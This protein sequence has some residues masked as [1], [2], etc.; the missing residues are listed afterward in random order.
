MGEKDPILRLRQRIIELKMATETELTRVDEEAR[1]E[2]E[3][4]KNSA[5]KVHIL[6]GKRSFRMSTSIKPG[7]KFR[8]SER[9]TYADAI[10]EGLR[11]EMRKDERVIPLGE[12]I[13][14]NVWTVTRG[15]VEEFG[16]R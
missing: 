9:L 11:E 7:G 13:K 10:R 12:D 3:E 14:I 16:I 15:L 2:I 5:R 4:A 1:Q 8:G 6:R